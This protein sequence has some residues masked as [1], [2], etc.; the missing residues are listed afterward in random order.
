MSSTRSESAAVAAS[1]T[2]DALSVRP[3]RE[4]DALGHDLVRRL[5]G[6]TSSPLARR[7]MTLPPLPPTI[8]PPG[9]DTLVVCVDGLVVGRGVLE[10]AYPPYCELVNLGVRPDY[11]R[12]GAGT[13]LV[14]DAQLRAR[15]A[16]FQYMAL[17]TERDNLPAQRFYETLGFL[18]ATEGEMLRML[19]PLDVPVLNL[20]LLA[21]PRC[22]FSSRRDEA[23]GQGWWRLEW[24]EGDDHLALLLCGG[25]CQLDSGGLLPT[26]RAFELRQATTHIAARVD[27]PDTARAGE[28]GE[29]PPEDAGQVEVRVTVTNLGDGGIVAGVRGVLLPGFEA[30][31][32]GELPELRV[33]PRGVGEASFRV[34]VLSGFPRD[35]L[36]YLSYPSVPLTAEVSWAGGSVLLSAPTRIA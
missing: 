19:A 16:G 4:S 24:R 13:A 20:F 27:A 30:D 29:Y 32:G 15:G 5:A 11:L 1:L 14:R 3:L 25:S 7:H 22:Q 2:H 23:L 33:E 12:R 36:R 10:A 9:D 18:P 6:V 34:A 21:H 35:T 26:V 17:Q 8:G 31:D 28:P